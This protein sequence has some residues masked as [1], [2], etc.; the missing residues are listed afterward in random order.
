MPEKIDFIHLHNH[1]E[2]SLLDGGLR[3]GKLLEKARSFHMPALAITDHGNMFGVIEFYTLAMKYGIKPIIGCEV[4]IAPESRFDKNNTHG[5]REASHHLILLAKNEQ[6]YRNLI[7]LVSI[8]YLQGFYYRPRIDKEVLNKHKEGLIG[9]SSCLKGEIAHTILKGEMNKASDLALQYKEIFK[10]GDF[11]LELQD[12]GIEDQFTVNQELISLSKE[13]SIPLVAT[14][15]CHYLEKKDAKIHDILLCLQTGKTLDDTD[16][17]K[18]STEEFYFKSPEEMKQ[19]FPSVPEA[20]HNTKVIADKCNLELRF[21]TLFL[22]PF[23]PPAEFEDLDAYLVHLCKEKIKNRYPVITQE[24]KDRLEY[25]LKVIKASKFAACILIVWDFIQYSKSKGIDVGPGRGS[26]VASLIAY[27]LGITSIDPLKYG[28]LFERFLNPDR[29]TP[30]D[31]DVD[32]RDDRRAE[33]VE[34]LTEKYG[35]ENVAQIITFGTIKA[36]AAIRD[37]GRVLSMPYSEVDKIAKMIPHDLNI[38]IEQAYKAVPEF[39]KLAEENPKV[40][41]LIEIAKS[42]EGITR[43][44]SV[45]A[46]GVV[47]SGDLLIRHT[48]LYKDPSKGEIVTQY[49][50]K[51]LE[52]IGLLKIDILG[53]KT[54]TVIQ[55]TLKMIEKKNVKLSA[56][57]ILK[58][59]DKTFSLLQEA[60]TVGVFQLESPGMRD[61]L[62]RLKPQSMHDIMALI[63]LYRPGPMRMIDDFIN[64]KHGKVP[65]KYEHPVLEG[66]LQETYGTIVYQEQVMQIAVQLAGFTMAQADILRRAMAKKIVDVMEKQRETFIKGAKQKVNERVAEKIFDSLAEFAEY[67]FNKPHSAAYAHV[68]Y[69][70]AYLKANYPVDFMAVLLTSELGNPD[71]IVFYIAECKKMSIEMLPPDIN[72]SEAAFTP[73]GETSIRFG[74]AAIKNVGYTAIESIVNVRKQGPFTSLHDFCTRVDLRVVNRKVLESLIKCGAFDSLN[75]KRSA[76]IGILDD[77]IQVGQIAQDERI[78]GQNSLFDTVE[79]NGKFSGARPMPDIEE[80][81]EPQLLHFERELLGLYTSGHPLAEYEKEL[82]LFTSASSLRLVEFNDGDTVVIGG[83]ILSIAIKN[84]KR[85][86]RMAIIN[87]EDLEGTVEV[88]VFP[89]TYNNFYQVLRK[90]GL[91]LVKGRI[92]LSRDQPK[93]IAEN[94]IPLDEAT[95]VLSSAVHIKLLS[96]GLEEKTLNSLK[97]ILQKYPGKCPAYFHFIQPDKEES[98]VMETQIKVKPNR[99]LFTNIEALLGEHSV[100]LEPLQ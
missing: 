13:L 79:E 87:L 82:S 11:Y 98:A 25:E 17:M 96:S 21:D 75:F 48:P 59:D 52:K 65:V 54:L 72:K 35:K 99:E 23:T 61:L 4:Y 45:H 71:K 51:S 74:L 93:I 7:Q 29:I 77:A 85:G 8:G 91:F 27:I 40:A 83:I 15:D 69:Q 53:L 90:E 56:N 44:A 57:D 22:P 89:K 100:W 66:I 33:V 55:E 63:A 2:Y 60:K 18:Y 32:F 47:I 49:D 12:H 16:R 81:P 67:G 41:E 36:K 5:I 31:I 92:D 26:S 97:E 50:M 86:D 64:R 76:L 78:K 58:Y 6:G 30:P 94:F 42:V 46:A 70:T 62:K 38:T 80:Y 3:I 95:E 43:H 84:T 73:N 88:I 24:V 20:I 37:V 39:S 1:T 19:L 34:Y 14:N 28:L 68:S 9:I 10:E